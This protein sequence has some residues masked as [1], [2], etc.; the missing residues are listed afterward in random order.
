M[1]KQT[2]TNNLTTIEFIQQ[3]LK[4]IDYL[5]YHLKTKVIEILF[6]SIIYHKLK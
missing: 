6:Q 3:L 5:S 1:T 2:V 4:S